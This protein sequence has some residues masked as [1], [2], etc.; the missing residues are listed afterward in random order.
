MDGIYGANTK[1]A[2]RALQQSL[3]LGADGYVGPQTWPYLRDAAYKN[4]RCQPDVAGKW[5]ATSCPAVACATG[6]NG[7]ASVAHT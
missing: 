5:H 4:G 3:G 2:V 7:G 1:A 6:S